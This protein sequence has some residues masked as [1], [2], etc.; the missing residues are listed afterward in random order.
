MK[1]L[2]MLAALALAI[3]GGTA[4]IETLVSHQTVIACDSSGQNC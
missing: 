3:V 4:A 1:K 2:L